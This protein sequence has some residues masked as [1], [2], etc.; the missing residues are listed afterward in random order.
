[1]ADPTGA[2]APRRD[3]D[4][5]QLIVDSGWQM[6][7]REHGVRCGRFA[8]VL[9]DAL[10]LLLGLETTDRPLTV[11][12]AVFHDIGYLRSERDHHRKSFDLL[13]D[14]TQL[15]FSSDDRLIVACAARYHGH[16][17]PSIEHAGFTDM[18]FADQRRVRRIAAIVRLAAA[19][20]ASHLRLIERI[21]VSE[22]DGRA[23]LTAYAAR[24]PAIERDR[25]RE[26]AGG[27]QQLTQIPIAGDVVI[28]HGQLSID[29][30]Q[31]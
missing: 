13:R 6:P 28:E 15:P 22:D 26:S 31:E 18:S 10:H 19:L 21:E 14:A 4:I 23:T 25:L 3:A 17:S 30:E 5:A 16:T 29:P 20:D 12:A 9:F 2:S 1:M 27:F 11:A 8:G 24:E 7:D